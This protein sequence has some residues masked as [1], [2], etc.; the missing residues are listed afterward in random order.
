[1]ER[2]PNLSMDYLNQIET[3]INQIDKLIQQYEKNIVSIKNM[4]MNTMEI[5]SDQ[6]DTISLKKLL[7][8]LELSYDGK[9]KLI[10]EKYILK[11]KLTS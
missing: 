11:S 5:K 1:M 7:D 6:I 3:E 4:I 10:I 8:L 9:E 2:K